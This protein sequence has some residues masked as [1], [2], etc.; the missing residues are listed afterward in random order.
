MEKA[1]LE[2]QKLSEDERTRLRDAFVQ[3]NL[4][5]I[6]VQANITNVAN[7]ATAVVRG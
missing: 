7:I 2:I 5:Q 4:P 3:E 1:K 6:L